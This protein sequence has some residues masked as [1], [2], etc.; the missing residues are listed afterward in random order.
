[1]TPFLLLPARDYDS[2]LKQ[3]T[4]MMVNRG[5]DALSGDELAASER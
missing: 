3:V 4:R 1:M 2:A 5:F